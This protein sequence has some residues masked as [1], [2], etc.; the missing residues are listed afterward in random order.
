MHWLKF[1]HIVVVDMDGKTWTKIQKPR[2]DAIS[3]HE[4]QG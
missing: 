4:S 2:G 3:I 1:S